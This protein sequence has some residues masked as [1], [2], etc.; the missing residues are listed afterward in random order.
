MVN[1][2]V[3]VFD[4]HPIVRQGLR[5][6][7]E[8]EPGFT[9]IGEAGDGRT[10]IELVERLKPDLAVVDLMLPEL[11][12]L[13]VTR[14]I[15]QIAPRTR[16]LILSMHDDEAHVLEALRAG[17]AGYV[18]KGT[19]MTTLAYGLRE[20]L[21]GR[22]YL[23][24]PLSDRAIDAYVLHASE[25]ARPVDRYEILSPREREVFQLAAQGATNAEIA[26]R[27]VISPRTAETHRTNLLRKLGLK[28]QT[29][30]V[31]RAIQCGII[32]LAG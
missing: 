2:T 26:D 31:R 11:N 4:D 14:R 21:E 13:D 16:V 15:L 6:L 23:S 24:P 19:S 17:A 25:A 28:S 32:P 29:E 8:V 3:A 7:L 30:L 22:R 12:G 10:A 1:A 27:L 18:L 20:A 5:A 9:M